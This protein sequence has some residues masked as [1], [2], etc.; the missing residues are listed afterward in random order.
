M[1]APENRGG[2]LQGGERRKGVHRPG[3]FDTVSSLETTKLKRR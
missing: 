1:E 3:M 2:R